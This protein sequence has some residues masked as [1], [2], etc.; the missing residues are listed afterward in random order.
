[1]TVVDFAN[2]LEAGLAGPAEKRFARDTIMIAAYKLRE[3]CSLL[4]ECAN[5][6]TVL[7][8]MAGASFGDRDARAQLSIET[9]ERTSTRVRTIS[10]R[11]GE[12]Q[13]IDDRPTSAPRAEEL[14]EW[15][16]DLERVATFV[17][18]TMRIPLEEARTNLLNSANAIREDV[19]LSPLEVVPDPEVPGRVNITM[20][21]PRLSSA[22]LARIRRA[23]KA[24][25][26]AELMQR[27]LTVVEVR[28]R[29]WSPE[30]A[31][32]AKRVYEAAIV[33]ASAPPMSCGC[34]AGRHA[35]HRNFIEGAAERE[36]AV[37]SLGWRK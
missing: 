23:V 6:I 13:R 9:F 7:H 22:E 18:S 25:V 19:G 36:G 27:P 24:A 35:D 11:M 26:D 31:D 10:L 1:M 16:R 12:F 3:A 34:P 2:E 29:P 30:L 14:T 32:L 4:Q 5:V 17:S 37:C 33:A 15:G 21:D 28:T 20:P 8:M